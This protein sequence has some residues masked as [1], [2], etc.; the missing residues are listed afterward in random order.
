MSK[1]D[2]VNKTYRHIY[3]YTCSVCGFVRLT[4]SHERSVYGI[5]KKCEPQKVDPNQTALPL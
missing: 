3:R 1:K 5:C 2:W 4:L